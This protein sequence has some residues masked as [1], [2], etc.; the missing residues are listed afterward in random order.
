MS[1]ADPV[2]DP[3]ILIDGQ[4]HELINFLTNSRDMRQAARSSLKQAAYT[5]SGALAGGFLLGPI[6]GMVGGIAGSIIGFVKSDGYDGAL[7]TIYKLPET[8]KKP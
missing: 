4:H 5:G 7:L 8:E 6:G 2:P 1:A 3:D